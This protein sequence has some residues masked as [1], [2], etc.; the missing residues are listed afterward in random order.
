M[1]D[2]RNHSVGFTLVELVATKLAFAVVTA[3]VVAGLQDARDQARVTRSMTNLKSFGTAHATYSSEWDGRQWTTCP[4]DLSVILRSNDGEY[5]RF[6][7]H[8]VE[9][10]IGRSIPSVPLG[11]DRNG[12]HHTTRR[13]WAIQPFWYP[14]NCSL[15]S[16]RAFHTKPFNAYL[17]GKVFDAVF[18]APKDRSV[19]QEVFTFMDDPGEWPVGVRNFYFSTY[20][21]SIAGQ[22]SPDVFRPDSRG[23]YQDPRSIPAG[24]RSPSLFQAQYPDLKTHMLEHYWLQSPPS[25]SMPNTNGAPWFFN[26][27]EDSTPVTLFFDGHLRLLKVKEVLASNERILATEPGQPPAGES[28]WVTKETSCFNGGYFDSYAVDKDKTT[29]FHVFTRDGIK[30]RDTIGELPIDNGNE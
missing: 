29:S 3:L 27:G 8:D 15:G 5:Q 12:K 18:W 21:T 17:N 26:L 24:F 20:C 23:G 14:E 25:D 19:P 11:F 10:E 6:Y 7:T 9:T 1:T 13:A 30:G 4:D 16:F 22:V 28:L 2:R